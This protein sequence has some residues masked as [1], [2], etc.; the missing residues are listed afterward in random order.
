MDK[1][2]VAV[3]LEDIY[4]QF[5][6]FGEGLE[7]NNQKLDILIHETEQIREDVAANRFSKFS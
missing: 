5:R 7:N 2:H 3:L 4:S 6:T 1:D